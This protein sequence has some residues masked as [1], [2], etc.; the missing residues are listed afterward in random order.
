MVGEPVEPAVVEREEDSVAC[1]VDIGLEV[2]VPSATAASKA[3]SVF[4]GASPAPP[5][6]AKASVDAVPRH[7][8]WAMGR[9][10]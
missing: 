1:E 6:W 5:R 3:G 10:G 9:S 4:S 2:S 7:E 8:R